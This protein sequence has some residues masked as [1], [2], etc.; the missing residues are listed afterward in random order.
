V[1]PLLGDGGY[2]RTAVASVTLVFAIRV[3]SG[4][5]DHFR[6]PKKV[7][8]QRSY[9]SIGDS[10]LIYARSGFVMRT[11]K[12]RPQGDVAHAASWGART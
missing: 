8:S 5:L 11:I 7:V 1:I 4:R 12:V 2:S 3:G 6:P 10:I 9:S